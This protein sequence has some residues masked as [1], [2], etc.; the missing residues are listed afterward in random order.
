MKTKILV[1]AAT[2]AFMPI[3]RAQCPQICSG[4]N[5]ALGGSALVH[6]TSG[7]VNTAI[8][9]YALYHNSSGSG[10]TAVGL[11]SLFKNNADNNTAV[12]F[13][14]LNGNTTG[15]K[16]TAIGGGALQS[17][18]N[19]ETG[20]YNTASGA[21][22]LSYNSSGNNNTATGAYSLRFNFTGSDNTANGFEALNNNHGSDNTASGSQALYSNITGGSN[23]ASGFRALY[24]N[25]DG[26]ANTAMGSAALFRNTSG[27][28]NMAGGFF[29][30][31]NNTTGSLNTADGAGA[32]LS[33]TTGSS[34]IALGA[35]AGLNLTTGDNNIDIGNEG[36]AAE[37]NT[38]RI[39]EQ[40]TQTATFI[41][42]I[43]GAALDRGVEVVVDP[44]T[45]QL[46]VL[47]SSQRFK[48]EIKPIG[49]A[50]EAIL[51]LQPVTF[52]YKTAIRGT[53]QFGL[54]AEEV[55]K[56]NP[57]LIVR[58]AEGKSYGVRYEAVNAMLLNEFLKEHQKVEDQQATIARLESTVA[59][60]QKSFQC[61]LTQQEE[62]IAALASSLQKVSA[63]IAVAGPS[64][65]GFALSKAS[66]Q[67]VLNDQ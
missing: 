11:Q 12:G 38:I 9:Q 47:P 45:G 67:V 7:G 43:I 28:Y 64:R 26:G 35:L 3:V 20:S 5:T 59:Q 39:G 13:N 29:A 21:E 41:A 15:T 66:P 8:G 6:N 49:K 57:D 17:L 36:V 14:A 62:Q 24:S 42:G 52:R 65:G 54:V 18:F 53:P 27:F 60:Q 37:A 34:N 1:V 22:S 2:I 40:G 10:N 46:G 51:A 56:V 23:T 19:S 4:D 44:G 32:L 33:N 58:D 63:Q 16:N 61:K 50:S 31:L 30:L 55:A 25:D 48:A